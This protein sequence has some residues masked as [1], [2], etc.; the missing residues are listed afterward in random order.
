LVACL[1]GCGKPVAD[2][3]PGSSDSQAS[4]GS[5]GTADD[6]TTG[7]SDAAEDP[8]P[9]GTSDTADASSL[10][11]DA[12]QLACVAYNGTQPAVMIP[13]G[14]PP[15]QET[16][17]RLGNEFPHRFVV[18][19]TFV[20]FDLEDVPEGFVCYGIGP[21]QDDGQEWWFSELDWRDPDGEIRVFM[22][23]Q[24]IEDVVYYSDVPSHFNPTYTG[25]AE[26][27]ASASC[28]ELPRVWTPD[29]ADLPERGDVICVLPTSDEAEFVFVRVP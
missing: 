27:D 19:T 6:A 10:F 20:P 18:D 17:F 1:S 26:F 5:V 7:A 2:E 12:A 8:G 4:V 9:G 23:T 21:G 15:Y 25:S 28:P 3:P 22:A 11:D 13:S 14:D 29:P 24:G 16:G